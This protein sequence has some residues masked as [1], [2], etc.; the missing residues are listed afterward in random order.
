MFNRPFGASRRLKFSLIARSMNKDY[1]IS[2]FPKYEHPNISR[3]VL[4]TNNLTPEPTVNIN[5]PFTSEK[6]VHPNI[7]RS[8]DV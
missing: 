8:K 3:I 5:E 7:Q 2:T 6:D 4:Y 1:R